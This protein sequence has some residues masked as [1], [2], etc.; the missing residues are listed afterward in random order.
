MTTLEFQNITKTYT[1]RGAGQIT[2]LDDVSFTLDSGRTLGLVGQSGSGKST[3]AKILTQLETPTSGRVLLDGAPVPRRGKGLRR[4]RQQL[5]M[6]FQDPFA[7]LNPYHSIRYHL[8]R[9]IRL[10]DVVPKKDTEDEVRRLLARVRLDADAVIDRRPH[11]LSGGQRQRVA[12]ARAL[13]SRPSILVADEP[14]SMLDVSI[15]L[16]V[17]TLLA[18]LQREEG[19][20]VLYIT[21]DLATARH[22][23]DEIM[24]LNQGRVVEYGTADDV[25]LNPQDP[26]TRELRAASPDPEKHFASAS[27]NGGAL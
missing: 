10:D 5:R 17:L 14:V 9:P 8:E 16:G 12:I 1:V 24:V 21:H 15:R 26:Y 22:F 3:I 2:A 7:S 13:A 23:S 11:E 6:V 25:I 18:D 27:A 19:L 20:G 4:Y